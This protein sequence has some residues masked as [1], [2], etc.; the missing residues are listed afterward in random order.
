MPQCTNGTGD[1]TRGL[2]TQG[3][4][5]A[6]SSSLGSGR[7]DGCSHINAGTCLRDFLRTCWPGRWAWSGFVVQIP[8]DGKD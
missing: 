8:V 5:W 2:P 1:T 6:L 7:Q 3:V 4:T